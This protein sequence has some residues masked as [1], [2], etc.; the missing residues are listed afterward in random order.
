MYTPSRRKYETGQVI[1]ASVNKLPFINHYGIVFISD[2]Q[3]LVVHNTPNERNKYGGNI[4]LD[5][6]EKFLSSRTIET[7]YQTKITR[8]KILKEVDNSVSKPFNLFNW[9]CEH[10]VWKVW[11]GYPLSP[12]LINWMKY[13]AGGT[14][15]VVSLI[16]EKRTK[17]MLTVSSV[18]LL[19]AVVYMMLKPPVYSKAAANPYKEIVN[20]N[21]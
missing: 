14:F 3:T 5:S 12:Q 15:V 9:N 8:E 10:F 4:Q 2:G 13:Y 18:I 16:P 1:K 7:V 17:R 11:K 19:I 21:T 20:P 6:L